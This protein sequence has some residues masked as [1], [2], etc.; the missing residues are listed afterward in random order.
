MKFKLVEPLKYF[1]KDEVRQ[2]GLELGLPKEMVMRQPF[3]GPGLAV[4]ILGEVTP[5]RCDILREADAIVVEE[6]K[7]SGLVLQNLAEF[8]RS[9]A[10]AQRRRHGRRA[11]V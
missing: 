5:K 2:F 4:R 10:R 8:R 7:A 9:V 6:M 3:P 11:H 1:F